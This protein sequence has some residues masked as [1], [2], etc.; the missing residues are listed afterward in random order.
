MLGTHLVGWLVRLVNEDAPPLVVKKL[1]STLVV[2][3]IRFPESWPN[4]LKHLIYC[5]SVGQARSATEVSDAP[6]PSHL[7]ITMKP[8]AKLAALWFAAILVEE[9]GKVDTKNI[10]NHHF[11]D[12]IL[13]NEADA[14]ELVKNAIE[15]PN[16]LGS[17]PEKFD[18]RVVEAGLK[19]F[20]VWPHLAFIFFSFISFLWLFLL[21]LGSGV[22]ILLP[23]CLNRVPRSISVIKNSYTCCGEL[24]CE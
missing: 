16:G 18:A 13:D 3:F 9:V 17:I 20:Q 21:I 5:L 14:V 7:P 23:S 11:Y 8:G 24:A 6:S 12:K 19:T 15:M 22:G 10:K 4:C 1:C 2:F